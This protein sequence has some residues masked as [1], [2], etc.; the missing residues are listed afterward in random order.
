M[1]IIPGIK[2]NNTIVI[3][4]NV[5]QIIIISGNL[6]SDARI[7]HDQNGKEFMSFRVAVNEKRKD[8]QTTTYYDVTGV[9]TGVFDLLKKGQGVIVNGKFSITTTQKEDKEFTNYNISAR[10]IELSGSRKDEEGN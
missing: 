1:T 8:K 4:I 9:K 2:G 6:T 7:A 3:I 10:D 5:M